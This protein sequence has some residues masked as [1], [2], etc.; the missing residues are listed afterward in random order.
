MDT[1]IASGL[2]FSLV[3]QLGDN[4]FRS[5][6][7]AHTALGRIEGA[8]SALLWGE[9]SKDQEIVTRSRQLANAWYSRHAAE[10]ADKYIPAGWT[11]FPWINNY[12]PSDLE[13]NEGAHAWIL[14][15]FYYQAAKD[16]GFNSAGPRYVAYCEA[17]RMRVVEMIAARIPPAKIAAW[18]D[19]QRQV[20]RKWCLQSGW[21]VPP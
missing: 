6:E 4:D 8:K 5:R 20:Q 13:S 21:P 19:E 14:A 11:E 7:R 10:L 16:F 12:S 15:W 9:R 3:L 17:T 18:V 1:A 2:F